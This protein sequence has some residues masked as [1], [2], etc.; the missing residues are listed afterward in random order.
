MSRKNVCTNVSKQCYNTNRK[1]D[2]YM[3]K[4]IDI[5]QYIVTKCTS[6]GSPVSNLQLQKILYFVQGKWLAYNS[7]PLFKDN[8]SAWQFGPVVPAVYYI[9][10]AYGGNKIISE[11]PIK[12]DASVRDMIDPIIIEKR[13]MDPWCLVN[14]THKK[15]GA[16]DKTYQA[17]KGEYSI[18]SN[19]LIREEFIKN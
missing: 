19:T 14:D 18:I 4:A 11:Y 13:S 17:G 12:L 10:C 2:D 16:W 6:D 1:E 5:A 15:G 3:Y 8:I 7:E 9:Y